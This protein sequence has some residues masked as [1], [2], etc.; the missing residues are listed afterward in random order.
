MPV[1]DVADRLLGVERVALDVRVEE[2]TL[3]VG[4]VARRLHHRHVDVERIRVVLD[5]LRDRA[6]FGVQHE[7]ERDHRV[8]EEHPE[9]GVED[10]GRD[11]RG[12]TARD[13]VG[14]DR[15]AEHAAEHGPQHVDLQVGQTLRA[16]D[17]FDDPAD[18]D[19]EA[20]V[21]HQVEEADPGLLASQR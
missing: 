4:E 9:G 13:G 10:G 14:V 15:R 12:A 16:L 8:H 21:G 20:G 1:Q 19:V 17:G 7:L 6:R 18:R 5:P 3:A 11:L 2:R